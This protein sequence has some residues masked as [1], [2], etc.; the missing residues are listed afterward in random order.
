MRNL[1]A[2]Y[3]VLED[4][5]WGRQWPCIMDIKMGTR[6]YE[7]GASVD[8]VAYEKSKFS[9]QKTAGLRIQGI[10]RLDPKQKRYVELDKYFGR[11]IT[12]MDELPR[13]L[14]RFFPLENKAK[15]VKL[16][17]AVSSA[18]GCC[19]CSDD[20]GADDSTSFFFVAGVCSFCKV[21]TS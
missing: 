3:L 4:L 18:C 7:D 17:E 1:C 20:R 11:S 5:T 8:K 9:L 12:S 15:T 2:E 14:G 21:S 6:S 16:L 10:K 13:A 19:A